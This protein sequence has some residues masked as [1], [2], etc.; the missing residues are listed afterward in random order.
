MTQSS[1]ESS[2]EETN[3]VPVVNGHPA[4]EGSVSQ[5]GVNQQHQVRVWGLQQAH[6]QVKRPT[7]QQAERQV[8][9]G[10]VAAEGRVYEEDGRRSVSEQP[11]KAT[12]WRSAYLRRGGA[13]RRPGRVGTKR[14]GPSRGASLLLENLEK[15]GIPPS[16]WRTGASQ[17]KAF[18]L[19][20]PKQQRR[21]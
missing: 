2:R 9:L 11:G 4:E 3:N 14:D 12:T 10:V 7:T 18:D 8:S 15:S 16:T 6:L 5:A 20:G 19:A 13:A 1:L 17:T 21:T